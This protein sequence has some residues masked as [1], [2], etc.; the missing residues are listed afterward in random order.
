MA[1][2]GILLINTILMI[3]FIIACLFLISLILFIV[4]SILSAKDKETRW[5]K[6]AK[7]VTGVM[8]I[9]LFLPL[10]GVFLLLK[11]S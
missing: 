1:F 3:L 11:L 2:M 6:V 4:F 7:I 5:K 10:L 9:V 8:S